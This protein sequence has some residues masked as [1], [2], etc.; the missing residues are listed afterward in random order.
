[1]VPFILYNLA[2]GERALMA[3]GMPAAVTQQLVPGPWKEKWAV[4]QPFLLA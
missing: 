4:M 1:M 2:P 3:A